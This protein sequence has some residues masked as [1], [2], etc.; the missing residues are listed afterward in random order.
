ME[1]VQETVFSKWEIS[2][3]QIRFFAFLVFVIISFLFVFSF[4]EIIIFQKSTDIVLLVIPIIL[5]LV[6]LAAVPEF[7][8]SLTT[9]KSSYLVFLTEKGIYKK[10]SKN[11][12]QFISWEQMTSYD[13]AYFHSNTPI[14]KLFPRPT[15]FFIKSKYSEDSFAVDSLGENSDVLRAYLKEKSVPFG[16]IKSS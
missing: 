8:K 15:R 3:D 7:I 13:L 5:F 11:E 14:G 2:K 16:F 10:I 4:F 6:F 1:N 12:N 9:V